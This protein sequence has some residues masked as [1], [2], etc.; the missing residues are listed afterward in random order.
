MKNNFTSTNGK[1]SIFISILFF[2]NIINAQNKN[3]LQPMDIFEMEGV[4]DPQI[5]P[6]G[7]Q[8]LYV[9]SGSDVMKDKRYSNIW[10]INFNG[11]D[12]RPLQWT[13]W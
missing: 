11:S 5:S 2:I 7:S 12:N 1:I 3:I 6:D 13:E 8:I 9:R 10:I 4:S